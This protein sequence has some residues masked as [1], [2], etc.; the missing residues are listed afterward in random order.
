M[1]YSVVG[2]NRHLLFI[3]L[4]FVAGA[5]IFAPACQSDSHGENTSAK[6]LIG[7]WRIVVQTNLGPYTRTLKYSQGGTLSIDNV[8][9]NGWHTFYTGTW[10]VENGSQLV[11]KTLTYKLEGDMNPHARA[12][13]SA[14]MGTRTRCDF[15]IKDDKLTL[16]YYASPGQTSELTRVTL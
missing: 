12:E 14:G 15:S 6:E 11:T 5:V 2:A 13:L 3:N 4:F 16:K 1:R 10:N 8:W 7:S 9:Q